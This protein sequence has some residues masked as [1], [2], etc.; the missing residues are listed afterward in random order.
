MRKIEAYKAAKDE[1]YRFLK[2]VNVAITEMEDS[3]DSCWMGGCSFAAAKRA[4][5]DLTKAL[6]VIRRTDLR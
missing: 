4:S 5:M 1:A 2:K 6:A 3:Q